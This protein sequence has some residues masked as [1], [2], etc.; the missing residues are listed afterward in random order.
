MYARGLDA[1]HRAR[2]GLPWLLVRSSSAQQSTVM[3]AA[4]TLKIPDFAFHTLFLEQSVGGRNAANTGAPR[5][6]PLDRHGRSKT[7]LD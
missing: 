2:D 6:A 4:Q 3:Q 7:N 1:Y 5:N